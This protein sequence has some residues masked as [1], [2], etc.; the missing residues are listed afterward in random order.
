[1]NRLINYYLFINLKNILLNQSL[2]CIIQ[3][4]LV[5]YHFII[6]LLIFYGINVF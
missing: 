5:Y 6:I 3:D 2:F 4:I 1:M